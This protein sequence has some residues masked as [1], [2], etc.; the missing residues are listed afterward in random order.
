MRAAFFYLWLFCLVPTLIFSQEKAE[1]QGDLILLSIE[2]VTP[3]HYA[4]YMQ[5]GKDYKAVADKTDFRT[6]WVSSSNGVFTYAVNVGKSLSGVTEYQKEWGEW[7]NANAELGEQYDKYKHSISHIKKELWRYSP[8]YSYTPEGY[9]GPEAPTYIRT[10]RGQVKFGSEEAINGLLTEFKEAWTEA[11]VSAPYS[12][13][14]NEFGE[15]GA[16]VAVRSVYTD[17][18]A[19][20]AEQKEVG[21]KVSGE[22]LNDLFTRWGKHIREWE[23][24]EHFPNPDLTHFKK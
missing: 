14:W 7:I 15:D 17:R 6:F 12:V 16:C 3:G 22:K 18:E 23:E 20:L 24:T 11:K 1:E 10:Y 13:Y 19:W 5:W 8:K 4:D 2:Y 21:E 9:E